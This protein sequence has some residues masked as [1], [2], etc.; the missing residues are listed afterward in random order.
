MYIL[1]LDEG[2]VIRLSDN[3]TVAPCQSETDP[4]FIEY[5][6]WVAEGNSPEIYNTRTDIPE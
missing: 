6:Q 5:N 4:N 3:T 1:I 2:T